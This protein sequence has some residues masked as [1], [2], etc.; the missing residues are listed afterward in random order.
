MR[1]S[2]RHTKIIFTIGPATESPEVLEKLLNEGVDICRLNMAHA[3]HEWTRRTLERLNQACEKTG[4]KVATLMDVKGP[5][6]RTGPVDE[7]F[8]FKKGDKVCF[9]IHEKELEAH[10]DTSVAAVTVNY[11]GLVKDVKVGDTVLGDSGLIRM[12]VIELTDLYLLCEVII[13]GPMGSRRH[14]NLPGVKVNLP[15][16]TRKDHEDIKLG[17]EMGVDFVALS[18]VREADDVDLLRSYLKDLGS[19]ARIISKIE[20]QSGI[21]NLDDIVRASDGL[22]VA[23]GD[24]GIEIPYEELPLTQRRA[25]NVCREQGT[26]VIVAT[27]MLESMIHSPMPT[28]AEITDVANAALEQADCV[29]LSGETSVG[30]YPLECVEVLTRIIRK[31]ELS[32]GPSY[33]RDLAL[34]T[35]KAKMLR[36]AVI[37]GSELGGAGILVF[38]RSG[39]LARSLAALRPRKSPVYAFTDVPDVFKQM[40]ILWGIEPFLMDFSEVPEETVRNAFNRLKQGKWCQDG[41]PLVVITTSIAGERMIDT[42][43]FRT[44][45]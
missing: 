27:H 20:D 45:E 8:E 6:V 19:N 24:L 26:P 34:K 4:R 11:P 29:M 9:Y 18:F 3:T 36:S 30:E 37:L 43:Q 17:V 31:I 12:E 10:G 7:P 28:R 25:V 33:N 38:T 22:M 41:D 35:P 14:I 40:L 21:S 32:E 5:E 13:P 1:Y 15:A 39:F 42:I 44:V 2:Y 16:L 23:R